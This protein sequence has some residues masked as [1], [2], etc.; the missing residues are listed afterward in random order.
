MPRAEDVLEPTTGS[1][2]EQQGAL[3]RHYGL[4]YRGHVPISGCGYR[5]HVPISDKLVVVLSEVYCTL[6]KLCPDLCE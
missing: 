3:A 2:N 5:G 1:V 4:G 6:I